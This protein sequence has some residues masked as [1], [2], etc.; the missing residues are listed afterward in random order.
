M[1]KSGSVSFNTSKKGSY[2]EIEGLQEAVCLA[3]YCTDDREDLKAAIKCLID[4]AYTREI[5]PSFIDFHLRARDELS[6][7][8]YGYHRPV[9]N[10]T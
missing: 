1:S 6:L 10:R 2:I 4:E 7:T 5:V 8:L 3:A 9:F